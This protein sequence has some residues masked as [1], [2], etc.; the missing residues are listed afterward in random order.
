[1]KYEFETFSRHSLYEVNT[2]I[3]WVI[4]WSTAEDDRI[5]QVKHEINQLQIDPVKS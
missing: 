5:V 2:C 3:N 1:M 4:N